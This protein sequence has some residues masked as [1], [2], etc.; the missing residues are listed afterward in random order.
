MKKLFFLIALVLLI[1]S[2]QNVFA[3]HP[4]GEGQLLLG[5]GYFK[6]SDGTGDGTWRFIEARWLPISSRSENARFG[7]YASGIE[8]GSKISDYYSHS[9]EVG[10]GLAANFTLNPGNLTDR[11]A[12]LNAAWKVVNSTGKMSQDINRYKNEQEDQLLFLSGGFLVR[13][14]LFEGPFAQQKI[15]FEFQTPYASRQKEIWNYDTTVTT[16]YNRERF[17]LQLENGIA[18]IYLGWRQN[19]YIMPTVLAAYTYEK[20]SDNSYYTLGLSLNL[21]KGQYGYEILSVSYQPKFW[22]GGS[23]IDVYEITLNVINIF[24]DSY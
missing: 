20:G 6:P 19:A 10:L 1:V 3:Q 12:W 17:K 13:N 18:P 9:T 16:P 5:N 23:R 22:S 8:V 2:N 15:M 21:A 4:L 14:I 11:Y 7:L 24:R